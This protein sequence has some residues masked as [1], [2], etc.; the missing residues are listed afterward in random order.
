MTA[1]MGSE[2]G[3]VTGTITTTHT[4]AREK[5]PSCITYSPLRPAQQ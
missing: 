3:A 5:T 1:H 4:H 2:V